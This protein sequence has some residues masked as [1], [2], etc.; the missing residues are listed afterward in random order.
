MPVVLAVFR[1]A[2]EGSGSLLSWLWG[3]SL[4]RLGSSSTV[5][6]WSWIVCYGV[7]QERSCSFLGIGLRRF[8]RGL[9]KRPGPEVHLMKLLDPFAAAWK[10]FSFLCVLWGAS[11]GV[12]GPLEASSG[13]LGRFWVVLGQS[14]D[15]LGTILV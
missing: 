6:E 3:V 2:P 12:W 7:A 8:G 5:L 11:S 9:G 14:W 13:L 4:G 1:G 10:V 15:N